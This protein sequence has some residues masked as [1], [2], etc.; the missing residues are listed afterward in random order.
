MI[1]TRFSVAIHILSLVSAQTDKGVTSDFIAKSV[2]TNPVVIRRIGSLLKKANLLKGGPGV[3][4]Y[5]LVKKPQQITLLEIYK[6][7]TT[8][9]E[10]FAIHDQPNP[11]CDVGRNIQA[12]LNTSLTQAQQAMENELKRQTLADIIEHLSKQ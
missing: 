12:T 7:V 4:G 1:N 11:N 2:N 6:A 5:S 9:E 3:T 8:E 10:L